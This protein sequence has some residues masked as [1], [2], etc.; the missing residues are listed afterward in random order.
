MQHHIKLCAHIP[1]LDEQ[2]IFSVVPHLTLQCQGAQIVWCQTVQ[3]GIRCWRGIVHGL[4]VGRG[5]KAQCV[6]GFRFLYAPLSLVGEYE[7][8]LNETLY[9]QTRHQNR[10]HPRPRLE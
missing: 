5:L 8:H 1:L 7:G 2:G 9:A 4:N 10:R 6:S 3:Q